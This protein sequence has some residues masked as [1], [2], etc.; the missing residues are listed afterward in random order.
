MELQDLVVRPEGDVTVVVINRAKRL[1]AIRA[2]TL[3][4]LEQTAA[5]LKGDERVRAVVITGAGDRAFSAGADLS[6]VRERPADPSTFTRYGQYVM[7]QLERMEKP[8]I[9]AVNG[10]ALGGGLEIVLACTLAVAG[11][12]ARFGLP[13]LEWSMLPGWGGTQRLPRL[14]GKRRALEIMLTGRHVGAQES[15]E[16]GLVN[17]VVPAGQELDAALE[18]A[19]TVLRKSAPLSIQAAIRV[20]NAGM[21]MPLDHA[22]LF[23][24][25]QM[26]QLEFS[27]DVTEGR[28]AF[29][30]KR[31]PR[32]RGR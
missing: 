20:V 8:V 23:E 4:E 9:A 21:D 14:V 12:T 1:N 26:A 16:I 32:F 6:E 28:N 24:S 25:Q 5:T 2:R 29:R 18:L 15:L 22:V 31:Q 27:D 7:Q 19:A 3:E 13:E 17:Q 11:E 10:L 30:E